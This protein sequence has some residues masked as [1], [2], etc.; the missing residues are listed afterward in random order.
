MPAV[1]IKQ[2]QHTTGPP[3][4][5]QSAGYTV[6]PAEH[7]AL[8]SKLSSLKGR[9]GA[10]LTARL[11]VE[12]TNLNPQ[13]FQDDVPPT[14]T[15]LRK[16]IVDAALSISDADTQEAHLRRKFPSAPARLAAAPVYSSG[17]QRATMC[18]PSAAASLYPMLEQ[19]SEGSLT[20]LL[21][22]PIPAASP[23]E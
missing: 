13:F 8:Q 23:E 10:L 17:L 16:G 19:P 12:R 14:Q 11:A 1:V 4:Y 21:Q 15:S 2:E 3:G 7:F 9:E 20:A 5:Q 6:L 18:T 22:R